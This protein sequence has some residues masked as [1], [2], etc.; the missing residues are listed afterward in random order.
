MP[1]DLFFERFRRLAHI[2]DCTLAGAL[3]FGHPVIGYP[4]NH[5]DR[6]D[7]LA[8]MISRDVERETRPANAYHIQ[9]G[10]S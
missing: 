2:G 7:F 9:T 10:G 4:I 6:I 1:N 5:I 3:G 8:I